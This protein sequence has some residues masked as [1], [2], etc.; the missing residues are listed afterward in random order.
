MDIQLLFIDKN[1]R[2]KYKEFLKFFRRHVTNVFFFT[3]FPH[4]PISSCNLY[5][6]TKP[7]K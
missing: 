4:N 6:P 3:W 7:I 1:Q 2:H 5:V